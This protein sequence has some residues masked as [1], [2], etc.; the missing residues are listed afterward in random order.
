MVRIGITGNPGVGKHLTTKVLSRK[1]ENIKVVDINKIIISNDAFF[2]ERFHRN[3]VD[4]KR[5]RTLVKEEIRTDNIIV[6]G[7]LLPYLIKRQELEFI[8]ILRRSPY[9]LIDIYKER[10]YSLEK[11]KE[12]AA[13]EILGICF[14][15]SLRTFGKGKISEIDTTN[16]NLDEIV[17]R[18]MFDYEN[19]N[20]RQIRLIDWLELVYRNGDVQRFLEY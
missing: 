8:V 2:D 15:D 19:K 20:K 13:S 17:K 11:I 6:V 3:E 16:N 4:L 10:K 1:F 5:A 18:I 9:S 7:H 12:N 14:Y